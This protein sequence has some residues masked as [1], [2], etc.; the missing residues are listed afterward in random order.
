MKHFVGHA[1]IC[2]G[3]RRLTTYYSG[4]LFTRLGI[5]RLQTGLY[6][7]Q[8][9]FHMNWGWASLSGGWY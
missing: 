8:N 3:Y 9:F 6:E 5:Y 2:D 7:Y 4:G 1:W